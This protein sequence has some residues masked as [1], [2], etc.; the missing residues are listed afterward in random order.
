MRHFF[1]VVEGDAVGISC[2]AAPSARRSVCCQ[3]SDGDCRSPPAGVRARSGGSRSAR[4][5]GP[6]HV[7]VPAPASRARLSHH[8]ACRRLPADS[9]H[10]L[11]NPV[12]FGIRVGAVGSARSVWNVG[13]RWLCQ[14]LD[15]GL[16][17]VGSCRAECALAVVCCADGDGLSRNGCLLDGSA[18]VQSVRNRPR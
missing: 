15:V 16:L 14:H 10:P 2:I 8:G 5:G 7:G 18:I 9:V 3:L 17:R 13:L 11:A 1:E 12:G 4:T 6:A